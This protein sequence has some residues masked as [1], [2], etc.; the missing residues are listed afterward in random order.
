[1]WLAA[2]VIGTLRLLLTH[3]RFGLLLLVTLAAHALYVARHNMGDIQVAYIPSYVV[4]VILAACNLGVRRPVN[5]ISAAPSSAR[6]WGGGLAVA[7]VIALGLS[8]LLPMF[9]DGAWTEEGRRAVWV[10]E[11]EPPFEVDSS[12][13]LAAAIRP[14]IADLEQGAVVFCEWSHLYAFYYIAHVEAQRTDLMFVQAYPAIGQTRLAASARD[15]IRAEIARRPI[16]LVE[17]LPEL[18]D[19]F[20]LEPASRGGLMLFRVWAR[21]DESV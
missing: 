20:R 10:P 3:T 9:R 16:Y 11:G 8:M 13:R 2:A 15:L 4:L 18:A 17:P 12:G 1:L 14:L 6:A 7:C 5:L 21:A 19:E